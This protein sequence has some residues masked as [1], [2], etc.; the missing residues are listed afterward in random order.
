MKL[1]DIRQGSQAHQDES[2]SMYLNTSSN[3][4]D[5]SQLVAHNSSD[6]S[7]LVAHKHSLI[8]KNSFSENG[9]SI[10]LGDYEE[11]LEYTEEGHPS[12]VLTGINSFRKQRQFCD[13]LLV[14]EDHELA[15]HRAVLAACSP[16]MF[17]FLSCLEETAE[18]QP[19]YKL[20]DMSYTGFQFLV[21][22][23]YTGRLHVPLESVPGVYATAIVLKMDSAVRACA[24]FLSTNLSPANCLGIRRITKDKTFKQ[25]VDEYIRSHI[26]EIMNSKTFYG[27]QDLQVEL[28]GLDEN[29]SDEAMQRRMFSL[30]LDWAK[31]SLNDLKPKLDR[32][33]EK[34]NV[35]YLISDNTLRDCADIEDKVLSG[36]DDV[37]QDY[38]IL[39]RRRTPSKKNGGQ[40]VTNG[41]SAQPFKKF[42][43][44]PEESLSKAEREWSIVATR[45][46]SENAYL[47][48]AVLDGRLMAITVH[49]R[50]VPIDNSNGARATP[51]S[52]PIANSDRNRLSPLL[53]KASITPLTGMGTARC[54]MGAVELD[55][56]LVVCGGYDRGECLQTVEAFVVEDNAWKVMSPMN[57]ARARFGAAVLNGC[58]YVCG[59]SDGWKDQSCVEKFD[60]V[61]H[62]WTYAPNM[63]KE[64]SSHGVVTL[65]GKLYCVGGCE[66][67]RSIASCEVYDPVTN[68]W[69]R[70]ASLNTA[71]SQTCVCAIN[72]LLFAIGGTDLWNTLNTVEVYNPEKD[73]WLI[74]SYLNIARRGAGVGIVDGIIIVVGG[75][76]G[77]QSLMST[78]LYD[79]ESNTWTVGPSLNTPRANMSVVTI[80]RRLYAVG[81]FSGKKFLTTIEWLDIDNMEW[82]GH[83]PRQDSEENTRSTEGSPDVGGTAGAVGAYTV[84][85]P[86]NSGANCE[87]AAEEEK[88]PQKETKEEETPQ[89]EEE[90]PQKEENQ[91]SEIVGMQEIIFTTNSGDLSTGPSS[92]LTVKEEAS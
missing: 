29:I 26:S 49:L 55:G 53:R 92:N 80:G 43:L 79:F 56:K 25:A 4:S 5:I 17:D 34:V 15:V 12:L 86:Q 46:T 89:E 20:K 75:S 60:P 84:C 57:R 66:G 91:C 82:F 68:K 9:A 41:G 59:G 36:N 8:K 88:T 28:V 45:K 30:V 51:D 65:N 71:R 19:T 23:M 2:A 69:S 38:K 73:E 52:P 48:I 7:Q 74:G 18:S 40:P 81:G 61:S 1:L 22:Y 78:E 63:L 24:N 35:L 54:A 21:D 14:V 31:N 39:T 6:M 72:G 58:L 90:T 76:D 11:F 42:S 85:V 64:R 44:N 10:D 70:I 33:I 13:I 62:K 47:A 67:Q 50:P 87:V 37:V 27:L 77:A 16:Y 3:S 83:T 32:L